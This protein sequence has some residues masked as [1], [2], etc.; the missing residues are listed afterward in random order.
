MYSRNAKV[1]EF[2]QQI[3]SEYSIITNVFYETV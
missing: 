2:V 3:T 1:K